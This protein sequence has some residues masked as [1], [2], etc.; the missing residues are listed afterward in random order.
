MDSETAPDLD[1]LLAWAEFLFLLWLI[2]A[3]FSLAHV[4][5]FPPG[6]W[7]MPWGRR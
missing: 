4:L 6:F 2:A 5:I 7:R 1:Y 3:L